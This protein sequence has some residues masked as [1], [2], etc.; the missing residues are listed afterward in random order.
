MR[1]RVTGVYRYW[2]DG[3]L[4]DIEY[5]E[6]PTASYVVSLHCEEPGHNYEVRIPVPR[7]DVRRY[8]LDTLW[9]LVLREA[10]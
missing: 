8:A 5:A 2:H 7:A 1:F 3:L 4:A 9:D 6:D 10:T